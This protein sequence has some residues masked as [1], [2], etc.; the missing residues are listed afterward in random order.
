MDTE[1]MFD[2]KMETKS[3]S[4]DFIHVKNKNN[5]SFKDMW[6]RFD[7]S[8]ITLC[9]GEYEYHLHRFL[10]AACSPYFRSLFQKNPNTKKMNF[11]IANVTGGD[12]QRIFYY[13][14]NGSVMIKNDDIQS[15]CMMLEKFW[16]PIPDDIIVTESDS[17]SDTER[18]ID[19]KLI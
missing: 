15:F 16:M 1:Q 9:F 4:D 5:L 8:D 19:G 17:E 6:L 10:L 18:E 14:Y 7:L 13:M 2:N 3:K 11:N 12:L